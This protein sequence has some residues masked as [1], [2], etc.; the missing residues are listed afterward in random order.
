MDSLRVGA[1]TASVSRLTP[2]WL[3][4][5]PPLAGG[6]G[7]SA[8]QFGNFG[9]GPKFTK[10]NWQPFFLEPNRARRSRNNMLMGRPPGEN[11]R[12]FSNLGFPAKVGQPLFR[13]PN[14]PNKLCMASLTL[15]GWGGPPGEAIAKFWILV[16]KEKVINLNFLRPFGYRYSWASV[17]RRRPSRPSR[18]GDSLGFGGRDRFRAS[19]T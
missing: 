9:F 11:A 8:G 3:H 16:F 1:G 13:E 14:T 12:R 6:Q 7:G 4:Q 15:G 2:K 10:P 18:P 17:C 5:K 19:W